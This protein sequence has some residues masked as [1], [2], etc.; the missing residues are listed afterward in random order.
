M[1]SLISS[2]ADLEHAFAIRREV[3]VDEQNVAAEDEYDEFETT[4]RHFLACVDKQPAGTARWRRTTNGTKLERF[5]V[6]ATFR[7]SGVGKALVQAVLSD[8]FTQTP[9][10]VGEIYL[11][12]QLT[13]IPLYAGFGFVAVG[14]EFDEC[15]IMHR[16]MTLSLEHWP[17][18]ASISGCLPDH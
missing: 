5:A 8:V 18:R 7:R 3:F 15:G 16:K 11:N 6:R 13:A 10:P 4:S 14:P 9:A 17:T 1:A 2:P 12:A